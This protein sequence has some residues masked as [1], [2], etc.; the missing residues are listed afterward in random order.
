MHRTLLRDET[1]HFRVVEDLSAISE[2]VRRKDR[3]LWLD[4][5]K[6][7]RE[8][9]DLIQEELGLHPLAIEDAMSRHQRP[10]IE[11]YDNFYLVVFYAV[12]LDDPESKESKPGRRGLK[13]TR[14]LKPTATNRHDMLTYFPHSD[15]EG[16]YGSSEISSTA[17]G[18]GESII[19]NEVTMFMGQNYLVT[20]HD[21]PVKEIEEA[22]RRWRQNVEI[23][24][25]NN[26]LRN[27]VPGT[28]PLTAAEYKGLTPQPGDE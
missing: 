3:Y 23:I 6:P 1:N 28:R 17:V 13:G 9:F 25:A 16:E 11:H 8:D 4:L 26:K 22:A 27:V 5:E 15:Q 21:H 18:S 14:F 12:D 20:V 10:K 2:I 24:G 19:L 7:T